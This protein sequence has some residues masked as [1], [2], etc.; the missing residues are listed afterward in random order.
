MNEY[1]TVIRDS[2][3]L[4][5]G[6]TVILAYGGILFLALYVIPVFITHKS[7]FFR[8]HKKI[9]ILVIA[10]LAYNLFISNCGYYNL[11]IF[12]LAAGYTIPLVA[13]IEIDSICK[14]G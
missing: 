11:F 10:L 1:Q 4:S 6:I 5:M 14:I 13:P 12:I 3:G 9:C 8:K 7:P 2:G